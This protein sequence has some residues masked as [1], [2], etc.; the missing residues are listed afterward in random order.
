MI[1][2]NPQTGGLEV[3]VAKNWT[4]SPGAPFVGGATVAFAVTA[5]AQEGTGA[6][7]MKLSAHFLATMQIDI[8]QDPFVN[9]NL[10]VSLGGQ[11]GDWRFIMVDFLACVTGPNFSVC[12]GSQ[13]ELPAD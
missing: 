3:A 5:S 4:F 10:G 12:G 8:L 9:M 1:R 13:L 7:Q 6:L 2:A 11:C